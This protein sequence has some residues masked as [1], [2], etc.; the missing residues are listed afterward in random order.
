MSYIY[1]P[2]VSSYVSPYHRSRYYDSY[3]SRYYGSRYYGGYG[4]YN[5]TLSAVRETSRYGLYDRALTTVIETPSRRSC[6]ETSNSP[7]RRN[8]CEANESSSRRNC[9]DVR[10]S[11]SRYYNSSLYRSVYSNVR[12]PVV[13]KRTIYTPSKSIYH[14]PSR[15]VASS[16]YVSPARALRYN[17]LIT[18][19]HE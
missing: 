8:C 6:C 17:S 15:V 10:G 2:Y 13:H 18:T 7:N 3:P 14:S 11:P 16:T 4:L 12:S 9:C 19:Y 1:S 5:R